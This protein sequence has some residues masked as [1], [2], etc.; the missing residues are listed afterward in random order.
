MKVSFDKQQ[1]LSALTSAA[2][3]SQA[4]NTISTIEGLLF[5]CPPNEEYGEYD[6]E[7]NNVCRISAFD[8]EKGLRMTVDCNISEEG[9]Y[10]I[11][12][13]KILQIV[14]VLPDGE[15]TIE[16]DEKNKVTVKGG[17]SG[18]EITAAN[19]VDF[20]AMPLLSGDRMFTIPQY[21]LRERIDETSFAVAVNDQRPAFNGALF[22]IRN[23]ELTV[24]G[25]D[26]NRLAVSKCVLENSDIPDTDVIIPGKFLTELSKMLK[27]SEDEV[28]III[29]RK[30]IIFKIDSVW[31]F[32]RMIEAE[33]MDY[34]KVLPKSYMTQVYVNRRDLIAAIDR[35]S[36]IT[37][38]KLGGNTKPPVKIDF[39]NGCI[40]LFSISQGGSVF[41]KVS[42]A[43]DGAD[44]T[45]GF[46]CRLLL[47]S[48]KSCPEDCDTLR[49]RLNKATMGIVIEPTEGSGLINAVP[50]PEIFGDRALDVKEEREDDKSSFLYFVMPRRL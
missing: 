47:E 29:G 26:T 15:I 31:F 8:L 6:G 28:T 36:I 42:C 4:K 21:L 46:T 14:R 25:C 12:T 5:E 17:Q 7:K 9:T 20:P 40:E 41:E 49:I 11:N 34:E 13:S 35:A 10:I 27:D 23:G 2:G 16:I 48:L 37:E 18:F 38:D 50:D 1:L 33:Y 30:H 22:K 39:K 19:G 44:L 24:V 3:I 43:M 45:I 32:T